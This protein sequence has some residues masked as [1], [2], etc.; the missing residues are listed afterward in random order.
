MTAPA[1]RFADD[2]PSDDPS[3]VTS[4]IAAP[5][6]QA[7]F[8]RTHGG[9]RVETRLVVEGTDSSSALASLNEWLRRTDELRGRIRL[10]PKAPAPG[11]MGGITD[12]LVVAAGAGGALT[13]LANSLSV[14]LRQPRRAS[15]TVSVERPDGTRVEISGEHLK[16]VDDITGLLETSLHG[17]QDG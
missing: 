1:G 12:V 5:T 16:S 4:T 7:G 9:V 17:D 10:R 14:W 11:E 6:L 2:H 8:G 15:V 13:V 3:A